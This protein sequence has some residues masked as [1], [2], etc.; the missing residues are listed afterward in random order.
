[1]SDVIPFFSAIPT[2]AIPSVQRLFDETQDPGYSLPLVYSNLVSRL[3]AAGVTPPARAIVKRWLAAVKIGMAGRPEMPGGSVE[4]EMAPVA[5]DTTFSKAYFEN[6]PEAVMPALLALWVAVEAATNTDDEE[7][8]DERTFE[9]FFNS[10]L[11]LKLPEP[12]WKAFVSY[13]K[14]IR[15]GQIE[16]PIRQIVEELPTTAPG[17][18]LTEASALEDGEPKRRRQRVKAGE[19]VQPEILTEVEAETRR[20]SRGAILFGN[21]EEPAG[22][23]DQPAPTTTE[24]SAWARSEPALSAVRSAAS[25]LLD[26]IIVQLSANIAQTARE[27]TARMLREVADEVEHA[28]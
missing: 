9:D 16:R 3:S 13:S 28:G 27:A 19:A 23:L 2:K 1:M 18:D 25:R 5:S 20:V 10:M 8:A 24:T 7:A 22:E 26:E 21:G 15:S 4:P 14:A 6:L 11:A 12:T 17:D